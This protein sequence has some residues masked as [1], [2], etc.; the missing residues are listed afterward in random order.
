MG[1]KPPKFAALVLLTCVCGQLASACAGGGK[2]GGATNVAASSSGVISSASTG[3]ITPFASRTT[4]PVVVTYSPGADV[5]LPLWK[6][7]FTIADGTFPATTVLTGALL[8]VGIDQSPDL[9]AVSP[10]VSFKASAGG[11]TAARTSLKKAIKVE[12]IVDRFI[13]AQKTGVVLVTGYGTTSAV[14]Y[15][16]LPEDVAVSLLP[17]GSRLVTF[18]TKDT[19]FAFAVVA[20][21]QAVVAKTYL[22]YP[23]PPNDPT[24]IKSSTSTADEATQV[25]LTWTP[26]GGSQSGYMVKTAYAPFSDKNCDGGS[27]LESSSITSKR[28]TLPTKIY[29]DST[30]IKALTPNQTVYIQV[31][32]TN[33]RKPPDVSTGVSVTYALP[34]IAAATLSGTPAAYTNATALS[35]TVGGSGITSYKYALLSGVTDCSTAS[36]G[37]SWIQTSTKVT[38]ALKT[39]GTKLLCVLGKKSDANIQT[40]PTAYAF[41]LDTKAPAAFSISSP[42]SGATVKNN[43]PTISW[44][45][46]TDATYYDARV[47]ADSACATSGQTFSG[48]TVLTGSPSALA[49]GT[50]YICVTARDK[51]GNYTPASNSGIAFTVS[52]GTWSATVAS[53][54]A[55]RQ[56]TAVWD[57]VNSQALIWGGWDGTTALSDGG[58]YDPSTNSWTTLATS[59]APAARYQ[60]TAVWTG[61]TMLIW[62]G[63]DTAGSALKS[64]G[65]FTPGGAGSWGAMSATSAPQVSQHTAVWTGSKMIVWGGLDASHAAVNSGAIYDV[66]GNSWSATDLAD[67]DLPAGRYRH[68]AVWTGSKLLV[69]GGNDGAKRRGDGG[70]FDPAGAD[71]WKPLAA[72]GA[73]SAREGHTAVWTGS[74][75]IIFGGYDGTSYLSDGAIYDPSTDAWTALPTTNGPVGRADHVAVW[76]STNK[77]MIVWGGVGSSGRLATGAIYDLATNSWSVPSTNASNAPAARSEAS[78]VFSGTKL[79]IFGGYD[80][81]T[82]LDSGGRF[83]PP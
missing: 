48:L 34:T 49:D 11:Q 47:F 55:R 50:Y 14:S 16:L 53:L 7:L 36:Y 75:M 29:T 81:T 22:R 37:T 4:A 28:V 44:S 69:F 74:K 78:A 46:P 32:A 43:L 15:E 33:S 1:K 26:P 3:T 12:T 45:D 8:A 18:T 35:V 25:S 17:D 42:S 38:D 57:S 63:I 6:T 62:G 61:S 51:A 31:C 76:D 10:F 80:G 2:S 70:L 67:T 65:I 59:S 27:V 41:V 5:T 23:I 20:L 9:Q 72:T 24:D 54:S 66:A 56:A 73:P 83:Q 39:D 68:S 52:T 21:R 58:S 60:H 82:A 30:T 77:Q 64:G 71:Y 19:D 13:D 40:V 79:I